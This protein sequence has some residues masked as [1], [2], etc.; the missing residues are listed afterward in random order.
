MMMGVAVLLF[1]FYS[2]W[3][4]E[5]K[6]SCIFKPEIKKKGTCTTLEDKEMARGAGRGV[7]D[8]NECCKTYP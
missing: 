1:C 6:Q 5:R 3:P 2:L 4:F 8:S 7:R